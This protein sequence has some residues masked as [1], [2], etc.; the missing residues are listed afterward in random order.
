MASSASKTVPTSE[1]QQAQ[2]HSH[3][4]SSATDTVDTHHA[5]VTTALPPAE[6]AYQSS[7]QSLSE[8]ALSQLSEA[9]LVQIIRTQTADLEAS[10]KEERQS[11]APLR[12]QLKALRDHQANQSREL[13]EWRDQL[14]AVGS[15]RFQEK[16]AIVSAALHILQQHSQQQAPQEDDDGAFIGKMIAQDGPLQLLTLA[17]EARAVHPQKLTAVIDLGPDG[18][19]SAEL[20]DLLQRRFQDVGG[21]P[22][23]PT[24]VL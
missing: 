2:Q 11:W 14:K 4:A 3:T 5:D 12:K 13:Q 1:E 10:F 18:P 22:Y 21:V 8:E 6:Q 7:T 24:A 19:I 20:I 23:D 15:L 16:K 9:E 17:Q